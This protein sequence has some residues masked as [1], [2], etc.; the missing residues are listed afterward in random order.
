MV[1][2]SHVDCG[3]K[4]IATQWLF[5]LFGAG[6]AHDPTTPAHVPY[7][8]PE[9]VPKLAAA[10]VPTASQYGSTSTWSFGGNGL[11]YTHKP[12]SSSRM[13]AHPIRDKTVQSHLLIESES[14][15]ESESE[16][17]GRGETLGAACGRSTDH[18]VPNRAGNTPSMPSNIFWEIKTTGVTVHTG[19]AGTSFVASGAAG[20]AGPAWSASQYAFDSHFCGRFVGLT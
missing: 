20:G 16:R 5:V 10:K 3:P 15:S 9:Q 19:Q 2:V 13:S 12:I 14:E 17:G 4:G 7:V 8:P 18:A 1:S 6:P 11:R